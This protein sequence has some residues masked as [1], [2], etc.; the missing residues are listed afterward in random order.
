MESDA[1]MDGK[2]RRRQGGDD[3]DSRAT[4]KQA[5]GSVASPPVAHLSCARIRPFVQASRTKEETQGAHGDTRNVIIF[6][7]LS[8]LL[9]RYPPGRKTVLAF[10]QRNDEAAQL[11]DRIACKLDSGFG[12]LLGC[13][14][15]IFIVDLINAE[16]LSG[17]QANIDQVLRRR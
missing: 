7:I 3:D 12:R 17:P 13:A 2:R 10:A 15:R 9:F 16:T 1:A 4:K 8:L 11:L 14:G 5:V 6:A